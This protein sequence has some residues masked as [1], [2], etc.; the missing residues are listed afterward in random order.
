MCDDFV[1]RKTLFERTMVSISDLKIGNMYA[2]L[3][4]SSAEA[5]WCY[6]T[7]HGK[8]VSVRGAKDMP[9]EFGGGL[10]GC[11]YT[12]TGATRYDTSP[13]SFYPFNVDMESMIK[14]AWDELAAESGLRWGLDRAIRRIGDDLLT[15][16]LGDFAT[17]GAAAEG[18]VEK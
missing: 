5:M 2:V 9:L 15:N 8:H 4:M 11:C 7:F 13:V 1:P 6:G 16:M 12:Q 14:K 3:I 18:A 10:A 17:E